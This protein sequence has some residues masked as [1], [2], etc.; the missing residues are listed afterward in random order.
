MHL[1][2]DSVE[3][4]ERGMPLFKS[5]Q[6]ELKQAQLVLL[7]SL[8][9]AACSTLLD[10][11]HFRKTAI[12]SY[13]AINGKKLYRKAPS[14]VLLPG[15]GMLPT[16]ISL[17]LAFAGYRCSWTD[18]QTALPDFKA[19]FNQSVSTLSAG[20]QRMCELYLC[21]HLNEHL[22]H[23]WIFLDQPFNH[24]SPV[25]VEKASEWINT[26][27]TKAGVLITDTQVERPGIAPDVCYTLH[28]GRIKRS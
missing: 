11:V 26:A 13:I 8:Q 10:I 9:P 15:T 20:E 16:N 24:L 14:M 6:L 4:I 1:V 5:V 18:F 22:S 25:Y 28:Q 21:L 17:R 3:Y 12:N 7:Y 2:I 23:R 19:E 27:K